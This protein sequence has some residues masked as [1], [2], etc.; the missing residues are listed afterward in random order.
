ERI[1]VQESGDEL[2]TSLGGESICEKERISVQG[3]GADELNTSLGGES[4]CEKVGGEKYQWY[5]T[6]H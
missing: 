3:S 1:S 2:N 4:I 6:L 5:I